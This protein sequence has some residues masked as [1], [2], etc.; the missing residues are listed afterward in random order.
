MSTGEISNQ[1]RSLNTLGSAGNGDPG[2]VGGGTYTNLGGNNRNDPT[3]QVRF[4]NVCV[5][6]YACTNIGVV[7]GG[8]V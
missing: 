2:M 1:N 3:I 8:G 7:G 4:L 6:V 5:Y